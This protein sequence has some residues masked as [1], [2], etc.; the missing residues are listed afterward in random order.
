MPM[1]IAEV[2][3]RAN[4]QLIL[5]APVA[6]GIL[7]ICATLASPYLTAASAYSRLAPGLPVNRMQVLS[8]A[9]PGAEPVPFMSPDARYAMCRFD[10]SGGPV[11]VAA[12]LPP[13]LG[14]TLTV[15]T[16]QGDN[17]YAAASVPSRPTPITLALVPSEDAFLGVTPEA[18]GIARD[19]QPP[20]A[21]S[22]TRGIVIVR[23]PDKGFAYQRQVEAVLQD[24][25]CTA[26]SF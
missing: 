3:S 10:A 6:A 9:A 18:R 25:H 20:T 26:R 11:S 1:K 8:V 7:H 2:L 21:V 24:A 5:A 15:M 23:G 13:D 12:T 19:V 14:W 17:I 16:P 22:A 4:W